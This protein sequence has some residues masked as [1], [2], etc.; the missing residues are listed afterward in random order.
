MLK[1]NKI[2]FFSLYPI[3]YYLVSKYLIEN[4]YLMYGVNDDEFFSLLLRG[5]ITGQNEWF[6]N[7]GESSPQLIF[8]LLVFFIQNLNLSINVYSYILLANII[9]SCSILT[10]IF[11]SVD[12]KSLKSFIFV[13]NLINNFLIIFYFTIRPTYTF[14]AYISGFIGF[15]CLIA[16][17]EFKKNIYITTSIFPLLMSYSIRRESFLISLVIFLPF[18][19]YELF[20]NNI[21]K[22]KIKNSINILLL[23]FFIG[24]LFNFFGKEIILNQEKWKIYKEFNNTRYEIQDNK[25]ELKLSQ[26]PEKY[27]MT[28]DSYQLFDNYLFID[29]QIYNNNTL[30]L[31]KL[32]LDQGKNDKNQEN[33]NAFTKIKTSYQK[34]FPILVFY[35]FT[36][37]FIIIKTRNI[38]FLVINIITIIINTVLIYFIS[39][40]LR[41]PERVVLA[42]IFSFSSGIYI[43]ALVFLNQSKKSFKEKFTSIIILILFAYGILN[44]P[45]RAEIQFI[46][47]PAYNSFWEIQKSVFNSVSEDGIFVGN[48]S[49]FRSNWQNPYRVNSRNEFGILRYGWYTFSPY[50]EKSVNRYGLSGVNIKD[51]I[52]DQN[53]YFVGDNINVIAINNLLKSQYKNSYFVNLSSLYFDG[54]EYNT[55]KFFR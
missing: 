32:K 12:I 40:N 17:L 43:G 15:I 35:I 34:F 4:F 47:N 11:L 5:E 28:K 42:T 21:Y 27:S 20:S 25:L 44:K 46:S 22:S 26:K 24:V 54:A 7:I 30:N 29:N 9:V 41:L 55:Y 23:I 16:G 10:H 37:F 33:F 2:L 39:L 36:I 38:K 50:W 14:A 53:V 52:Y 51:F 13:F 48:F 3:G 49:S 1:N 45:I 19:L 18:I 31:T 8:G 6:T